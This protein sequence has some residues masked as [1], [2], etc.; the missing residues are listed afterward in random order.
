M[1]LKG[2]LLGKITGLCLGTV[3][4]FGLFSV[5]ALAA[6]T[7]PLPTGATQA[8]Q[9]AI[10]LNDDKIIS[11]QTPLTINGRTLLPLRTVFES[12]GATVNYDNATKTVTATRKENTVKLTIG[13]ATAY[14]NDEAVT[15]D[16]AAMSWNSRT[17]IP[18]RFVGEAFGATVN[19]DQ[20]TKKVDIYLEGA[21]IEEISDLDI[22]L[23]ST[24]LII[25]SAFSYKDQYYIPFEQTLGYMDQYLSSKI[26]F[27]WTRKGE[28]FVVTFNGQEYTLNA[29]SKTVKVGES[30]SAI[31]NPLKTYQDIVYMPLSLITDLF[32][33]SYTQDK[34]TGVI[35]IYVNRPKF[36]QTSLSIETISIPTPT[37]APSASLTDSRILTV[38][39]NPEILNP[40]HVP[41]SNAVLWNSNIVSQNNTSDH[42]VFGW[43][44]NNM[45]K[46]VYIAVTI[47]NLGRQNI[48]VS[49]ATGIY[50][51]SPNSWSN[52]DVGMPIA[53]AVL[54]G[55]MDNSFS[56]DVTISPGDTLLVKKFTLA[57]GSLLGFINDF[58]ISNAAMKNGSFKY[59]V[60]V[61]ISTDENKDLTQIETSPL[62]LAENTTH[63]RGNWSASSLLNQLPLYTV[64]NS[65][66]AYN[67]S[68]GKTDNLY[69]ADAA[70]DATGEE[71]D[72]SGHFGANY[73]VRIPVQN[74][75]E[76]IKTVRIRLSARGGVYC[77]VVRTPDG[78]FW[79]PVLQPAT[80][81]CNL[82]DYAA[83]PGE[84]YV[85]LELMHAGGSNLA[86]AIDL[87]TLE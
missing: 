9:I 66:A 44:I 2:T 42:R 27:S 85:D 43:H 52:Y 55:T 78:V 32:S 75:S 74:D 63:P 70:L 45:G 36:N 30:V 11:E 29:D 16:V 58:T 25:G 69:T 17:Y 80:Q 65:E 37:F 77:G 79:I 22:N 83:P 76:E 56:K 68:N 41:Q 23:N 21:G 33:G 51:T 40:E 13:N 84:S 39:D 48:L 31:T 50:R 73:T 15:L 26:N 38:S 82:Y 1:N 20:S 54:A 86:V 67:I 4:F 81:V 14:I 28:A 61:V 5:T 53:E 59:I 6:T 71:L 47:E 49:N 34:T 35:N 12:M 10:Y 24:P 64:G 19:W 57:D 60:R 72:N 87:T 18:L 46:T 62:P 7:E 8:P 3:V